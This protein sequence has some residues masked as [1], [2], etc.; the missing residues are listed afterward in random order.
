MSDS[1]LMCEAPPRIPSQVDLRVSV[2][3]RHWSATSVRLT[4]SRDASLTGFEPSSG[5]LRGGTRVAITG[6]HFHGPATC[7][8]GEIEVYASIKSDTEATCVAPAVA[9]PSKIALSVE[10]GG[11]A[12]RAPSSFSYDSPPEIESIAPPSGPSAGGT[13]VILRGRRLGNQIWCRFGRET[14]KGAVLTRSRAYCITPPHSSGDVPL[15]VS[16]NG[17]DFYGTHARYTYEASL[18][19]TSVWP[20]M[21]MG[22]LGGTTLTVRGTGFRETLGLSCDLDGTRSRAEVVS[23]TSIVCMAPPHQAG[24]VSLRVS[25]HGTTLCQIPCKY[26][27]STSRGSSRSFPTEGCRRAATRCLSKA[28]ISGTPVPSNVI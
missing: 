22:T 1:V 7:K 6:R 24:L 10:M 20:E 3:S 17:N 28:R 16:L 11:V 19:L 4:Y 8:F 12:V 14:T 18:K 26:C 25:L 27:M 9:R 15:E 23:P 2:D 21:A 13:R 5:P